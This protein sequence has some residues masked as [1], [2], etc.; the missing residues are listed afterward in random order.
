MIRKGNWRSR[1]CL[2]FYNMCSPVARRF[3]S[4]WSG[5]MIK[6][7][8]PVML[9]STT[10]IWLRT[11]RKLVKVLPIVPPSDPSPKSR[12]TTTGYS[13]PKAKSSNGQQ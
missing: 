2:D 13:T 4:G 1:V 10:I 5:R 3:R 7:Y 12:T 9:P 11:I 8:R 6:L